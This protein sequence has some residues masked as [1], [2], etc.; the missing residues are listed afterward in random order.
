LVP[1]TFKDLPDQAEPA[2][3]S[4]LTLNATLSQASALQSQAAITD[5]WFITHTSPGIL[6]AGTGDVGVWRYDPIYGWEQRSTGLP[7]IFPG[8]ALVSIKDLELNPHHGD[9]LLAITQNGRVYRTADGGQHWVTVT[10]PFT[11]TRWNHIHWDPM[12][13][14]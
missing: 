6:W 7:A 4:R 9:V 13:P 14:G 11:Q 2:Q 5:S 3:A 12:T 10:M 1:L 8:G